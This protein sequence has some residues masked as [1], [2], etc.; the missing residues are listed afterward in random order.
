LDVTLTIISGIQVDSVDMHEQHQIFIGKV[1]EGSSSNRAKKDIS[2]AW[3]YY[4]RLTGVK[5]KRQ[6]AVIEL[7]RSKVDSYMCIG[8]GTQTYLGLPLP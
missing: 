2:T 6:A 8:G 4:F 1:A 3:Q 7:R 5:S